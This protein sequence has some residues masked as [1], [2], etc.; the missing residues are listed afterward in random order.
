MWNLSLDACRLSFHQNLLSHYSTLHYI[1]L[2]SL[3]S[4]LVKMTVGYGIYH[5]NIKIYV[6]Y[7]LY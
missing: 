4:E 6:Q 2:H 3:D 5:T 1:A 7:N